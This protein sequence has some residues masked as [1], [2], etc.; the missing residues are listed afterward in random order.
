LATTAVRGVLQRFGDFCGADIEAVDPETGVMLIDLSALVM[1]QDLTNA[2]G[3]LGSSHL[4][5]IS[6][7]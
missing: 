3:V 5:P 6:L 1:Q 7:I 2:F 4:S